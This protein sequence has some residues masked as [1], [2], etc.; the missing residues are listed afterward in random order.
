MFTILEANYAY[1]VNWNSV[2]SA[3]EPCTRGCDPVTLMHGL[4]Q[5]M[6]GEVWKREL[7]EVRLP[8]SQFKHA[9]SCLSLQSWA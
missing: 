7:C 3:F 8:R 5:T 1:A 4:L 6:E 9:K 2:M